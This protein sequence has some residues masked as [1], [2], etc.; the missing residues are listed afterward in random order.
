MSVKPLVTA[1]LVIM[2]GGCWRN[3]ELPTSTDSPQPMRTVIQAP[4][5]P[6]PSWMDGMLIGCFAADAPVPDY[7]LEG[8]PPLCVTSAGGGAPCWWRDPV[9][10]SVWYRP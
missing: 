6:I 7:C 3:A 1:L 4:P 5:S 10:G 2:L 8:E 9:T